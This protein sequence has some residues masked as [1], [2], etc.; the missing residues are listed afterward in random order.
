MRNFDP[1]SFKERIKLTPQ[2]Y[3]NKVYNSTNWESLG[4]S[5]NYLVN[6]YIILTVDMLVMLM[7]IGYINIDLILLLKVCLPFLIFSLVFSLVFRETLKA[8]ILPLVE[9]VKIAIIFTM[10]MFFP[11]AP[12]N[13]I[14]IT[15]AFYYTVTSL[16]LSV[17]ISQIDFKGY[18][19]KTIMKA[20]GRDNLELIHSLTDKD[21]NDINRAITRLIFPMLIIGILVPLNLLSIKMLSLS[22]GIIHIISILTL[23][24]FYKGKEN[25][26]LNYLRE[27][28]CILFMSLIALQTP[29]LQYVYM[30]ILLYFEMFISAPISLEYLL[31]NAVLCTLLLSIFIPY[32][33]DTLDVL[34][35][36][37]NIANTDQKKPINLQMN[38]FYYLLSHSIFLTVSILDVKLL[39][40]N[41]KEYLDNIIMHMKGICKKLSVSFYT[42]IVAPIIGDRFYSDYSKCNL[43]I[44]NK[45][46]GELFNKKFFYEFK[47]EKEENE[48]EKFSSDASIEKITVVPSIQSK[49]IYIPA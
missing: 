12:Y 36:K 23:N 15:I 5:A 35:I 29:I 3:F 42:Y 38:F 10:C 18:I 33:K 6:C 8:D 49:T 21:V 14:N 26:W 47:T 20:Y 39:S 43:V 30:P 9:T 4:Y 27:D 31:I 1:A 32:L 37:S 11:I 19:N 17:L 22:I 16:T 34:L 28:S 48:I 45:Q 41:P 13:M 7:L 24:Y 40:N 25:S 46:D 2:L 44:E